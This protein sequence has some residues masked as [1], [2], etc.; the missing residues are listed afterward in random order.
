MLKG[1]KKGRLLLWSSASLCLLA[2]GVAAP[3]VSFAQQNDP[4]WTAPL[5]TLN[6][7]QKT[8]AGVSGMVS[9]MHQYGLAT[10]SKAAQAL[11][12]IRSGVLQVRNS[13]KVPEDL[14]HS[15]LLAIDEARA[16]LTTDSAP[17]IA[18]SLQTVGQ[19]V[20]AVQAKLTG[21]NPPQTAS[22][23]R[24]INH[25]GGTQAPDQASPA[26]APEQPGARV[27]QAEHNTGVVPQAEQAPNSNVEKRVAEERGQNGPTQ[28]ATPEQPPQQMA[29]GQQPA[30]PA[31][32]PV[33]QKQA[34]TAANQPAQQN[35]LASM[36]R[37][38]VVGRQLYD[39]NGNPVASIQDVKLGPDG[40]IQAVE[41]DVGGFLGIGSR[42]VA[43]PVDEL[44]LKGDR[45]EATSMTADQIRNQPHEAK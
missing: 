25:G 42:R 40:K 41:I 32:Q 2:T 18:W 21:Q 7:A 27:A 13:D 33:I 44:Q 45:I 16:A 6:D 30:Q 38:D 1:Q 11:E 20:Q 19:E 31:Q 39:S 36:K 35:A 29:Q 26:K 12:E 43:V 9:E 34:G 4:N 37:D 14:S 15:T 8:Y 10:R 17:T 23:E 3:A 24:P 5:N 28:Q 22:A